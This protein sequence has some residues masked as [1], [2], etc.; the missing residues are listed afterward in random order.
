MSL[1]LVLFRFIVPVFFVASFLHLHF[2]TLS[3][4]R[5]FEILSLSL[6]YSNTPLNERPTNEFP[7]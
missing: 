2:S 6:N 5:S 4:F 3:S 1:V 7:V